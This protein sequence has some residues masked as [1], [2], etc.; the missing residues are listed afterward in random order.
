ISIIFS[1]STYALPTPIT[2]NISID[3]DPI[4]NRLENGRISG[5]Q[6]ELFL[7]HANG[8]IVVKNKKEA[9]NGVYP[10]SSDSG[11]Q[12]LYLGRNYSNFDLTLTGVDNNHVRI[13]NSLFSSLMRF[14]LLNTNNGGWFVGGDIDC[15]YVERQ[16]SG[17]ISLYL[18]RIRNTIGSNCRHA[19]TRHLSF[20]DNS[21]PFNDSGEMNFSFDYDDALLTFLARPTTISGDYIGSVMFN[22]ESIKSRVQ[23]DNIYREQYTFNFKITKKRSLLNFSFPNSATKTANFTHQNTSQGHIG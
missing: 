14:N 22:G 21:I 18:A 6:G 10:H 4:T 23:S 11:N 1:H 19:Q 8:L 7:H 3:Y 20:V 12:Q 15:T 16:E 9:Y 5:G 13:N 17:F 2:Y